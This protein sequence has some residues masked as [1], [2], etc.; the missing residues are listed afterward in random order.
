MPN[1]SYKLIFVK[2]RALFRQKYRQNSSF[3]DSDVFLC[4]RNRE[5]ISEIERSKIFISKES[6]FYKSQ[7]LRREGK[8]FLRIFKIEKRTRFVFLNL[9]NREEKENFFL[10]ILKIENRKRMAIKISQIEKRSRIFF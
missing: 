3:C 8:N 10:K 6:C 7:K 2:R 4:N 1:S 5:E 9:I